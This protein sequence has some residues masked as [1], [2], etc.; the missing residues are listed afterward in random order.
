MISLLRKK[1]QITRPSIR[2]EGTGANAAS[3]LLLLLVAAQPVAQAEA[4]EGPVLVAANGGQWR[5]PGATTPAAKRQTPPAKKSVAVASDSKGKLKWRAVR[6]GTKQVVNRPAP[7]KAEVHTASPI[8]T[9]PAEGSI[10]QVAAQVEDDLETDPF[11]DDPTAP[12]GKAPSGKTPPRAIDP[13]KDDYETMPEPDQP[14]K[15]AGDTPDSL[16]D[17]SSIQPVPVPDDNGRLQ[18]EIDQS[19]SECEMDFEE[20][21]NNR[22]TTWDKSKLGIKVAGTVGLDFPVECVFAKEEFAGRHWTELTYTWKASALCHKPLYFEEEHLE[23]YG[24]EWGPYLQPVISGAHF[25]VTIPILPYK[26]GLEPPNECI[27][28]LGHY[29]PGNCAPYLIDPI[30]FSWRAA[31]FEAG[32]WVGG[33]AIVP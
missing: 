2:K 27:Y 31:L 13:N 8:D 20:L 17:D 14:G 19:L 30:P 33:V 12:S 16:P 5:R 6:P 10:R 3:L 29:R 22:L 21:R 28:A 9:E 11:D 1:H 23:R 18:S 15:P 25:F 4:A 32:A 7:A 24:H 26:M